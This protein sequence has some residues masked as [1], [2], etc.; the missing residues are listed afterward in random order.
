MISK[1]SIKQF[2]KWLNINDQMTNIINRLPELTELPQFGKNC[3]LTLLLQGFYSL[4]TTTT[5]NSAS[6]F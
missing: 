2:I 5:T 4:H 3:Q 6:F 1:K